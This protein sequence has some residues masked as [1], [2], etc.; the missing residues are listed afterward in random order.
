MWLL[1]PRS[2]SRRECLRLESDS[3]HSLTIP[4]P[5]LFKQ[6]QAMML[7]VYSVRLT[8]VEVDEE[9]NEEVV[10]TVW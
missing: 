3:Q 5:T 4:R 2:R 7:V 6:Q 1:R 9:V 8:E 10:V